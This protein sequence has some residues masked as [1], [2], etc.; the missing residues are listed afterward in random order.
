MIGGGVA[1]A[2]LTGIA[3]WYFG[4]PFLTSTHGTFHLPLIGEVEFASAMG[5]DLGVMLTVVGGVMLSLRQISRVEQRAEREPVPEGPMDIRLPTD[6]EPETA[7]T[8][9]HRTRAEAGAAEPETV[10]DT[11]PRGNG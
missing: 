7:G 9:P 8:G 6:R 10:T 11:T 2:G 3:A 5:F 4:R 1:L